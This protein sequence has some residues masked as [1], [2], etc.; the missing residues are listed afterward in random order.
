M[1][2]RSALVVDDAEVIRFLM[3]TCLKRQGFSSI[4]MAGDGVEALERL[5]EH[6]PD[7]IFTDFNMPNMSG[8]DFVA[9][10]RS[11]PAF[12]HIPVVL[13]SSVDFS[14]DDWLSLGFTNYIR[15]SFTGLELNQ[16]IARLNV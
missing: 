2:R 10:V 14:P 7:V 5:S 11:N 9:K 4:Y 13:L 8:G 12:A 15:K 1:R 16:A 6:L 3:A